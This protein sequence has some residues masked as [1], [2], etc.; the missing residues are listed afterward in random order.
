MKKLLIGIGAV[1]IVAGLV[2]G[3]YLFRHQPNG[4]DK[5]NPS[6]LAQRRQLLV[7]SSL[8]GQ[9]LNYQV[10]DEVT[11]TTDTTNLAI[12]LSGFDPA[13]I[14]RL[15]SAEKYQPQRV[16]KMLKAGQTPLSITLTPSCAIPKPNQAVCLI[17]S[18]AINLAI[19]VQ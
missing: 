19:I 7:N 18:Q 9:T 13:V 6:Q 15:G 2:V 14:E 3:G 5:D 4:V 17:A 1:S 12:D 8:N 10:G 16:L 11:L